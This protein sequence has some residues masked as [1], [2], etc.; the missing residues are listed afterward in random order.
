MRET[1]R[2]IDSVVALNWDSICAKFMENTDPDAGG[3]PIDEPE[4]RSTHFKFREV[5]FDSMKD[6]LLELNCKRLLTIS[7][8]DLGFLSGYIIGRALSKT[9]DQYVIS[10]IRGMASHLRLAFN[11]DSI[12]WEKDI[13]KSLIKDFKSNKLTLETFLYN[14]PQLL[15][16]FFTTMSFEEV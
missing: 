1:D 7:K 10:M 2:D 6:A 13:S 8:N 4:L 12:W 9:T 15:A 16:G 11:E 5:L 3:H 14:C